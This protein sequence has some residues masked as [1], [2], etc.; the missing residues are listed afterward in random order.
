MKKI[1]KLSLATTIAFTGLTTLN[2]ATLAEAF[3]ASKVKGEIKAQY[4]K[5]V[6]TSKDADIYLTGGK[7]N[8][9]TGSY[10]GLKAGATFQTSHVL[11]YKDSGGNVFK[12]DQDASGS[13]LSE[14]YLA[15]T[16]TNTTLKAGRQF[17]KTPLVAGS[18]SRMIK[19]S[20][21]SFILVNTDIPQT[22][23]VAGYLD[24]YA[25]RTDTEGSTG[26]FEQVGDN[27]AYTIYLKNKSIDT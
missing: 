11:D 25:N 19:D 21:E 16:L 23:L 17:I 1:V 26:E 15:Y 4:F 13:V 12:K 8:I 20:F 24:K 9:V 22:T 27:G 5:E 2:A 18:G 3:A 7:L 10:Y 14:S 6:Q